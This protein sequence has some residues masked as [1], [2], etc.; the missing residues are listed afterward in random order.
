MIRYAL[1]CQNEHRFEG[2]FGSSD[3]FDAQA[4]DGRLECPACGSKDVAKQIMAPHVASKFLDTE[5]QAEVLEKVRKHVVENYENVGDDF[6]EAARDIH[7]G[8]STAH[9]I[10]GRSSLE[11]VSELIE[12]GIPVAPMPLDP[13]ARRK[14][15]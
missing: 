8:R 4:A 10:Y 1:A 12:D 2:W 9:G 14:L 6:A 15:N 3:D 13:A 5:G 11:E 7:E